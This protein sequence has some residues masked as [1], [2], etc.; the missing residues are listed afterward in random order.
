MKAVIQRV[1]QAQV[2]IEGNVV[3]SIGKGFFDLHGK[4][5]APPSGGPLD[6]PPETCYHGPENTT[7]RGL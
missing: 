7:G 5:V 1:T 4:S 3:G 6:G 2:R